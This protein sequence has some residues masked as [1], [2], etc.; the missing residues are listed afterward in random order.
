MAIWK[1]VNNVLHDDM[2][3]EALTLPGWPTG[4]MLLTDEEVAVVRNPTTA[5]LMSSE[6]L[7]LATTYKSNVATLQLA[8]LNAM[9]NDGAAAEV[10]KAAV[11]S[12]LAELKT[13]YL[14]DIATIK[15]KYA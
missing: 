2:G 15:A 1:D 10:K 7:A 13:A 5:Q 9:L 3:G 11:I 12:D 14:S 8:W 6:L 4:M